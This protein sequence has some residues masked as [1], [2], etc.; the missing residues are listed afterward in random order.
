MLVFQASSLDL[1][2]IP[3]IRL[4]GEL[5]LLSTIEEGVVWSPFGLSSAIQ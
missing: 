2:R 5:D 4:K 1:G 3:K